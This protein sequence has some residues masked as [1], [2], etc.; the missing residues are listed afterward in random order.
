MSVLHNA[1]VSRIPVRRAPLLRPGAS[2]RRHLRYGRPATRHSLAQHA[3]RPLAFSGSSLCTRAPA[4]RHTMQAH[5]Q[6]LF[7]S[8]AIISGVASVPDAIPFSA[9]NASGLVNRPSRPAPRPAPQQ[10]RLPG[11]LLLLV[12]RFACQLHL[13]PPPA[14]KLCRLRLAHPPLYHTTCR[15][16][17]HLHSQAV[18]ASLTTTLHRPTSI[19][20]ACWVHPASADRRSSRGQRT[21]RRVGDASAAAAGKDEGAVEAGCVDEGVAATGALVLNGSGGAAGLLAEL[22]FGDESSS[23]TDTRPKLAFMSQQVRSRKI[24]WY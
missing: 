18:A 14:Q 13:S 7:T 24:R 2:H 12:P 15:L 23:L 20:P 19:P 3:T 10:P 4:R 21:T 9:F 8:P 6:S 1:Y 22:H 11:L 16:D 17:A 5:S